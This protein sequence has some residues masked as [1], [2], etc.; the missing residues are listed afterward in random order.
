MSRIANRAAGLIIGIVSVSF[1]AVARDCLADDAP[2][3]ASKSDEAPKEL[4]IIK[5]EDA[6]DYE[7][8]QVTVEFKVAGAREID[9]GVC[10]L[11]STTDRDDPKGFTAYI[12]KTAVAKFKE[13]PKTASPAEYFGKKKIRVSGTIKMYKDK[14]EIEV[15]S[16]KQITIVEEGDAAE[17]K[18]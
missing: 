13:D 16:P 8:K 10:F 1:I 12:L 7:G 11:N 9:S 15:S 5:P 3:T 17:R 14:Y 2:K 4:K 6:K 18:S